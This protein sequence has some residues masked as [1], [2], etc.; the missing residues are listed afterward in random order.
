M[1]DKTKI[2]PSLTNR[3]SISVAK[4]MGKKYTLADAIMVGKKIGINWNNVKFKPSDLLVGM[5]YELEHGKIDERTNVTGDS[6]IKTA[7]VAWA[8]LVE[9]PDYY[10]Q[11]MKIDPPE[12]PEEK[13]KHIEDDIKASQ[14]KKAMALNLK[15]EKGAAYLRNI[16][17]ENCGYKG[18]PNGKGMCPVCFSIMGKKGRDL[19]IP[20]KDIQPVSNGRSVEEDA[21]I[22]AYEENLTA[23]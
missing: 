21:M 12:S 16:V 6:R 19:P 11:L 13:K 8:H 22:N 10:V 15:L 2:E 7:K 23:Y 14:E 17:C 3:K 18:V 1:S 4:K 9:R 20:P 5:H